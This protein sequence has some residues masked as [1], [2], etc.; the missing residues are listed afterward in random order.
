MLFAAITGGCCLLTAAGLSAAPGP[1]ARAATARSFAARSAAV[2]SAPPARPASDQDWAAYLNGPA[3]TSF[4]PG[5]RAITPASV[6]RLA[7]Q[8]RFRSGFVAGPTVAGGA[9][10]VGTKSGWFY[11]LS[12]AT[13]HVLAKRFLGVQR[14]ITCPGPLGITDTAT[15]ERDSTGRLTVYVGGADGYLY[16][17]RATDLSVRWRSVIAV[18]SAKV[19][20]FFQW[21]SPTVTGG[22]IF[23]GIASNC[24]RPLVR[25][26]L[27]S[28]SQATGKRLAVY[29]PMPRRL[30]GGSIWSSAAVDSS[31]HVYVSTG[32]ALK[33]QQR[34]GRPDSITRLDPT[35]LRAAGS[36]EVPAAEVVR[37]GDFGSSP[38][39]FGR[40][41]GAC[42]KN[43]YFYALNR[44]TMRLAWSRQVGA[45]ANADMSCLAAAAYDG[46]DLYV[47]GPGQTISGVAYD[48]SVQD[49]D[50]DTGA[51]RWQTGLPDAVIGSPSVDGAGVL[52]V[53]TY[54]VTGAPNGIYLI[55]AATGTILRRLTGGSPD[56]AQN[57]FAEGR[58]FTAN[59]AYLTAWQVGS[60]GH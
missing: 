33:H 43:G 40:Y 24:D 39:I 22:R 59:G 58:L 50:P 38:T 49:L 53:G 2:R 36:F 30:I 15:V 13:G 5:Q 11:K 42:D 1:A 56:F 4:S 26:G 8:W 10:Y 31:G 54:Q 60:A 35:T 32:N 14:S 51:A 41:V 12:V 55:D 19:N 25:A 18:P 21:S 45:A 47:A 57:V 6:S 27:A 34:T 29:H 7:V 17:L 23:I 28:Y 37:D 3:H 44:S 16:A 46:N 48:G 20:N 9:V 52:A